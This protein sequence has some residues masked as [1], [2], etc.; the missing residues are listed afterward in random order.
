M[1][2][3]TPLPRALLDLAGSQ[4]GAL[5]GVQ[6]RSA[7]GERGLRRAATE[8][9]L[10]KLWHGAYCLPSAAA[11]QQATSFRTTREVGIDAPHDGGRINPLTRLTAA[12]LTLGRPVIACLHTAAELYGFAIDDHP[13]THLLGAGPS[14]RG[15]LIVHRTPPVERTRRAH[16]FGVVAPAETA[17]RLAARAVNPERSLA[18]LD[19]SL[20]S[21]HT[22]PQTLSD[23]AAKLHI[24]GVQRIR[25][26][27]RVADGRAESP[28][29]SWLRWA[30][31][32]AG[33]PQ[34]VPQYWLQCGNRLWFRI[35]LA[36]PQV[37]FGLEYDGVQFHTGP[38]LTRDRTRLN[39]LTRAGWT[40]HSVTAPMLWAGRADL[41]A[42]L[43]ED[44]RL[45]GAL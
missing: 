41:V 29:E 10:I 8:G 36:W 45:R 5:T 40:I 9:R 24:D 35:D 27:V 6:L 7:L 23:A 12:T 17:V 34:P 11:R 32:D 38:A 25:E 18:L 43:R 37:K 21:T 33:F 42:G 14:T 16:E 44:L 13:H 22:T 1:P 30:C 39:A 26:L 28:A 20:R 31:L 19:A 2:S 3:P 15:E 4:R